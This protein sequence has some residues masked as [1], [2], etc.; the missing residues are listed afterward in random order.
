LTLAWAVAA[1]GAILLVG[2]WFGDGFQRWRSHAEAHYNRGTA[3][4]REGKLAEAIAE[5]RR[6]RDNAQRGS[7]LAQ[8]S[9]RALTAINNSGAT[10]LA[11]DMPGKSETERAPPARPGAPLIKEG[12][13]LASKNEVE[14]AFQEGAQA[15]NKGDYAKAES[16]FARVLATQEK[17]LL[18]EHMYKIQTYFYLGASLN[19]QGKDAEADALRGRSLSIQL[20]YN[21]DNG[22]TQRALPVLEQ[23]ANPNA[24]DVRGW[25]A[26]MYAGM[27]GQTPVIKKLLDKGAQV[28]TK[29]D[30]DGTTAL[31]NAVVFGDPDAV[32]LL[33]SKGADVNTQNKKGETALKL[34]RKRLAES[35]KDRSRSGGLPARG[36]DGLLS[37]ATQKEY[38]EVAELLKNAGAKE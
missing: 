19:G 17:K 4:R 3:L 22:H 23:G 28:A 12:D 31:L 20:L 32:R 9:E 10:Q 25:T 18:Y 37:F 16:L 1:I 36:P 15:F 26:L 29:N 21:L 11:G 5:F 13:L 35:P 24:Q 34:A 8:L 6:A 27:A 33:L 7:K 2:L 38:Q 30:Q 14:R